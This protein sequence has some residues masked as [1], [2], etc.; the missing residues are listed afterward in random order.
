[1]NGRKQRDSRMRKLDKKNFVLVAE[2]ASRRVKAIVEGPDERALRPDRLD[3]ADELMLKRTNAL[4]GQFPGDTYD[5][6]LTRA[7]SIDDLKRG[8]PEFSGWEEITP[9]RAVIA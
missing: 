7:S 4:S 8:Y 3:D 6:I 5:V 9:E 1:M 2:I